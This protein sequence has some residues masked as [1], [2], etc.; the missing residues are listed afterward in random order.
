[1]RSSPPLSPRRRRVRITV[2]VISILALIGAALGAFLYFRTRPAQYRPDEQTADITSSL[3][4]NLP[5]DA[6]KPTFT[7]VTRAAGLASFRTFVGDRTSQMPEDVG[8]GA[9]WGDFDNDGDDD[10][11]LAG[12]GG[13]LNLSAEKLAPCQ[14][15][16]NLGNGAFREVEGFPETRIHG[17]GAAWGD[18]DGDGF[19]DLAVSG[20]HAL[21]LFHNEAGTGRFVRDE[22]LPDLKGFWSGVSWGDYDND[23]APDLYVCGYV[24]F[25]EHEADIARGSIQQGAF[26]PF[27][28]NPASYLGGTNLLFHNNRDGTFTDVAG[29]LKVQNPEGRSLGALWHDFDDDGWLDLYVANDISDN[30]FYHNTGGKFEDISHPALVADYRSAMGLA[31]GDYNRDGDDD[32]YVTHWVAQENALYDNL[33]ADFNGSGA[34]LSGS[35]AVLNT[36]SALGNS[37]ASIPLTPALIGFPKVIQHRRGRLVCTHRS[38]CE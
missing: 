8:P 35:A 7:D 16:E 33:W 12:A 23:R 15:Y 27:T 21:L 29:S 17:M 32:L 37:H 24:H 36:T 30:V 5:P 10:L 18:F 19:L 26:V 25:I 13:A 1:M 9:A 14:L 28:L 31:V 2:A 34:R 38:R 6:P 22:R 3:A 4:R 20:Y 11:F